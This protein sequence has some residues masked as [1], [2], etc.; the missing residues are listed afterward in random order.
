M[1]P[2]QSERVL[3][4]DDDQAMARLIRSLLQASG[5]QD[6]QHVAT[7]AEAMMAARTAEII[8]LDH[9]LPDASGIDLLPRLL[10][11]RDPQ[12][13]V[14]IITA[15]GSESL[16]AA[17]LRLGAEDYLVKDGSLKELLPQVLDRVRRI[18]AQRH[19]LSEAE[20]DLVRA[21]RLAAV[22]EMTVTLHHEINNPL[23]SA[24]A[25][26]ELLLTD[27][28]VGPEQRDALSTIKH[29][30]MRV[31]TIL[32]QAGELQRA[33]STEYLSGLRMIDLSARSEPSLP[34]RGRVA[35]HIA[36]KDIARITTLLLRHAGFTIERCDST[37]ALQSASARVGLSL[38]VLSSGDDQTGY[39][40][41]AGFQPP[42]DRP[43]TLI[44][45]APDAA[46][47]DKALAAGA[48][49]VIRLP[50]DPATL[51]EEIVA[52]MKRKGSPPS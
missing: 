46:S 14:L 9:Q 33:E 27:S 11:G 5:Y 12:P 26:V 8:L 36:E 39:D 50:L 7:A 20:H 49:G 32:K 4:V 45:F 40:P 30:L 48:D 6:V 17:A 42:G 15:Y 23:M 2:A 41:L 51:V 25:E 13:S 18:R 37:A 22:G 34:H 31:R 47:A 52:V 19:A 24:F 29:S 43:Y 28:Q 21:E 44:A 10:A 38:V 3:L 35:V 16:A 1:A